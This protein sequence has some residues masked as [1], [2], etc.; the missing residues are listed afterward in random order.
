M[1]Y[2]K[3]FY[4]IYKEN[5]IRENA[6]S[7]EIAEYFYELT[8]GYTDYQFKNGM[9]VCYEEFIDNEYQDPVAMYGIIN[10]EEIFKIYIQ[11]RFDYKEKLIDLI[12]YGCDDDIDEGYLDFIDNN[13][14]YEKDDN[15]NITVFRGYSR[16]SYTKEE[17]LNHLTED[18]L[19]EIVGKNNLPVPDA[20]K[21][22]DTLYG[23]Q[24]I[25]TDGKV[26]DTAFFPTKSLR[27]KALD[28]L[29]EHRWC[30]NNFEKIYY[31][32]SEFVD[33]YKFNLYYEKF[34][35]YPFANNID[36]IEFHYSN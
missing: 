25:D 31:Y 12:L 14:E 26:E 8:Q 19:K 29:E 24:I 6:T 35:N 16:I 4:N 27:D 18:E 23:I 22:V 1:N 2:R 13:S 9:Y 33:K 7:Q 5:W 17:F 36:N 28:Y 34:Q 30:I 15:G 32:I 3:L 11:H 21:S 10:N 20:R